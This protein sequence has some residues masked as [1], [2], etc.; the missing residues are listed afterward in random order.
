MNDANTITKTVTIASGGTL[1]SY[2]SFEGTKDDIGNNYR[3]YRR[4]FGLVTPAALTGTTFTFQTSVD[5]GTTWVPIYD[6]YGN[7]L[8]V[9]VGTS[10]FIPMAPADFA[11]VSMLKI[12]S[13]SA[14]A[15][16]RTIGLVLR[17][18]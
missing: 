8:S 14:E 16:G 4:L 15:A 10:R 13:G 17:N 7:A 3:P 18:V 6:K 5:G 2:V 9:A 1:S 11:A 12:V